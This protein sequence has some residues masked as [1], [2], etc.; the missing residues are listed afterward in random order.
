[1]ITGLGSF[2]LFWFLKYLVLFK[3]LIASSQSY[4]LHWICIFS[5]FNFS[6]FNHFIYGLK[7]TSILFLSVFLPWTYPECQMSEIA[8]II[9]RRLLAFMLALYDNEKFEGKLNP[10]ER[11]KWNEFFLIQYLAWPQWWCSEDKGWLT[12]GSRFL[13]K[14]QV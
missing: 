10:D 5:T 9:K 1:M 7:S 2:V 4:R 6:D 14:N 13:L 11:A 8:I 12:T 3:F